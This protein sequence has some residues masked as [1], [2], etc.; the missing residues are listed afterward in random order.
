MVDDVKDTGSSSESDAEVKDE[1]LKSSEASTGTDEGDESGKPSKANLRIQQLVREKN[2]AMELARHFRQSAVDPNDRVEFKQWKADRIKA[3]EEAEADGDISPAKLKALRNLMRQAD[4]EYA[5]LLQR[6]AQREEQ[7]KLTTQERIDAQFDSAEE[8]VRDFAKTIG[9]PAKNE[10]ATALFAQN[11]MLAVQN[12]PKLL[13]MW[14][15]GN[16]SCIGKACALVRDGFIDVVRKSKSESNGDLAD[17]RRISR[18][19]TLPSGGASVGTKQE[20]AKE[21]G[22]TKNTHDDAWAYIQSMKAE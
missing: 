19:P 5:K 10:Q 20:T 8:T 14:N 9:I 6:E 7:E 3:A 18:L 22:I 17:R 15:T 21:K 12:D 4:P 11:V 13:R 16:L 1:S 2:E